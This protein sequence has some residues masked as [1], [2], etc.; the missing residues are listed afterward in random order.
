MKMVA[1]RR[2][3]LAQGV[4]DELKRQIG[5]GILP[6]KSQLPTEPQLERQ[7]S[8]SRTVVREA[9]AELRAAG[10][11]TPIQG[12]GMFVTDAISRPS[13]LLTPIELE[14]V[15][16]TLELIEF[17]MGV[18]VEAAGIAA[19]RRSASQEEAIRVAHHEM[20]RRVELSEPTVETDFLF[21]RAIATATNNRYFAEALNRYGQRS[22]PRGQ[23]PTLPDANSKTYLAGVLAEHERVLDAISDQDSEA[24]RLAMRDH[25]VASQ[26]R[27]RR[28]A[29]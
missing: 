5:T 20:A 13:V 2:P 1:N 12:K 23:F 17:R 11:V 10:L 4:I 14:S 24:A 27:Y 22:I 26:K 7:F 18:E 25:L 15:P 6:P 9:I 28:L 21:H 3:R 19:Y 29:R 16:Q 8:V